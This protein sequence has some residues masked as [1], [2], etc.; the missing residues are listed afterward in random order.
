MN[1]LYPTKFEPIFKDKIWGGERIQTVLKKDFRPLPNCG[2][3]WEVSGVQ[4][5]ISIIANGE[6]AGLSLNDMTSKFKSEFVGEM[7]YEQNGN[8]FPL[9]IK[10]I[11]ANDDLSIQVH[12]GDEL[13]A[14]RHQSFGKTEMWYVLYAEPNAFLYNGFNREISPEEYE[15]RIE[16]NTIL[17]VLNKETVSAGD[18]FFIPAGRVHSIGKGIMIAEIQ[19]T[20]DITYR[21]YDFDRKDDSGLGR[22]LHTEESKAAI[23]YK[24]Y[25]SYKA[26]YTPQL[27]SLVNAVDC[28]YFKTGVIALKGEIEVDLKQRSSFTI[29]I[30]VEG[31]ARLR[32]NEYEESLT[33][34]EVVLLPSCFDSY[35]LFSSENC[36]IVETFVP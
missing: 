25:D 22:Q 31:D 20:S 26:D 3:T 24:L 34:G 17:E 9:L 33:K 27:N 13:A 19:Q 7:V 23:D 32:V 2:E 12:P 1:N 15:K 8:D 18:M 29:V 30:C 16:D 11:D 21:I 10:F 28:P 4:G 6:F 36:R 35:K 5:N 14:S